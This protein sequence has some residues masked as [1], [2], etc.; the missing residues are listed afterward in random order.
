MKRFLIV[1]LVSAGV[2]CAQTDLPSSNETIGPTLGSGNSTVGGSLSIISPTAGSTGNNPQTWKTN[3][4]TQRDGSIKWFNQSGVPTLN[5]TNY[6]SYFD[7]FYGWSTAQDDQWF[8]QGDFNMRRVFEVKTECSGVPSFSNAA[9][10]TTS[11]NSSVPSTGNTIQWGVFNLPTG[12]A[13]NGIAFLSTAMEIGRLGGGIAKFE[14]SVRCVSTLSDGTDGYI[15][16]IGLGDSNTGYPVNGVGFRYTDSENGGRLQAVTIDASA[17]TTTADTGVT[18]VA[19]AWAVYRIWINATGTSALFYING[20]LVATISATI[21]IGSGEEV[22]VLC[23]NYKFLGTNS[24]GL[25]VDYA[26]L[27]VLLSSQR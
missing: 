25:L 17:G 9:E 11:A 4:M 13:T 26:K 22:G 23:A 27:R 18:Y 19:A 10:W 2:A 16:Y 8:E 1:F 3:L 12:A 15:T 14:A 24:R 5:A 20:T 21:P 7:T 6:S